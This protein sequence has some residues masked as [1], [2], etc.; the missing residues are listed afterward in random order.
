MG[1]ERQT[2]EAGRGSRRGYGGG[3]ATTGALL[4]SYHARVGSFGWAVLR[5]MFCRPE[6][7]FV[8]LCCRGPCNCALRGAP[9]K[10]TRSSCAHTGREDLSVEEHQ[11]IE[12][13]AI[14]AVGPLVGSRALGCWMIPLE[15]ERGKAGN[16]TA[17]RPSVSVSVEEPRFWQPHA[18]ASRSLS[19]YSRPVVTLRAS[20]RV[21]IAARSPYRQ[22]RVWSRREGCPWECGNAMA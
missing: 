3:Q 14:A 17:H 8:W 13:R 2:R 22:R 11:A 1:R 9:L 21:T 6:G 5:S 18:A 12:T 20:A 19:A 15:P 7:P 4:N 16:A 10:L